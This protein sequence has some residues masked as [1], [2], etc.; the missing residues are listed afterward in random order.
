MS[1]AASSN[2]HPAAAFAVDRTDSLTE[3]NNLNYQ[4]HHD[5][6]RVQTDSIF[7]FAFE[8]H[9]LIFLTSHQCNLLLCQFHK[10]NH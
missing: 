6:T 3:L 2:A 8:V 7:I 10:F 9:F 4:K 1:A 5:A